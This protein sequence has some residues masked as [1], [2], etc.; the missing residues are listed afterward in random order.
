M[1]YMRKLRYLYLMVL[2]CVISNSIYGQRTANV[3][4]TYKYY[5][6]EGQSLAQAKEKALQLAQVE[7]I[8]KE[9]GT[10]INQSTTSVM[11][12][13]NGESK[14]NFYALNSSD[15]KGDWIET[16]G[17]P[18]Y[19]V[20]Y[21]DD[22]LIVTVTVSGLIREIVSAAVDLDVKFMRLSN[23]D[24]MVESTD[25]KNGDDI[26]LQF[27]SPV[28]GYIAVYLVD[29][30]GAFCLLPYL[31]DGL[32]RVKV[33]AG[34]VYT[35]FSQEKASQASKPIVDQYTMTCASDKSIEQNKIYVI[36]SPN[37][38]T[39]AVDKRSGNNEY[40]MA[41]PRQLDFQSFNKWLSKNRKHD[42]DMVVVLENITIR[43]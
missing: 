35:F 22:M 12:E 20:E 10:I 42:K 38:F 27:S 15:V 5:V 33:K 11:S 14:E 39:K 9:F 25:F 30:E 36:F 23:G 4:T 2:L 29:G 19:I 28:D 21:M 43:K 6:E 24:E 8:A 26:Y 18:K 16:K 34:E 13:N 32:G 7:A 40:G 17:E 37:M 41:L 1:V 31:R 3:T